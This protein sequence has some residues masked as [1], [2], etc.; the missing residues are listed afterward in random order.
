MIDLDAYFSRIGFSGDAPPTLATLEQLHLLHALA[1]PFENLSPLL[2]RE[3]SLDPAVLEDKLVR[4]ARGGYCFEQNLLFSHVL[5]ELGFTL[6]GL[7]ARVLWNRPPGD[8]P[9]RTH[10]LL[11]VEIGGEPFLADVGFGGMTQTA[12]LRLLPGPEQAT[13]HERYRLEKRGDE[14]VLHALAGGQWRALYQ[15]DLQVQT[16]ADYE[17]TNWYISRHPGSRFVRELVAGRPGERCRH[18]L[19]D[20]RYSRYQLDGTVERR[21]LALDELLCLLTEVFAIDLSGLP[22]AGE[23]LAALCREPAGC[24]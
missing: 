11:L 7:A 22:E 21:V 4:R 6:N 19:L 9:A 10:M 15:F 16:Q 24:S 20:N 17:I 2:G 23:R 12:P 14:F 3:V 18:A 1:I 13:P 8:V 5:R